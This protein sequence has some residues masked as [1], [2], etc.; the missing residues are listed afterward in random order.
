MS[1]PSVLWLHPARVPASVPAVRMAVADWARATGVDTDVEHDLLV[2]VTELSAN[3]V[4]HGRG[5]RFETQVSVLGD[6]LQ[7]RVTDAGGAAPAMPPVPGGTLS[8]HGRGLALVRAMV[9]RFSWRADERGTRVEALLPAV[10]RP[11]TSVDVATLRDV[12]GP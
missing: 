10:P 7:V 5:A 12:P 2:V 11:P 1:G 4:R 6:A 3:A 9:D 8:E